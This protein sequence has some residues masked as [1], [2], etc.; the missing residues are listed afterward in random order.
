M[1]ESAKFRY[2]SAFSTYYLNLG[3]RTPLFAR[4]RY[5]YRYRAARPSV[6]TVQL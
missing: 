4:N 2:F 1:E 3:T 5:R 6:Y